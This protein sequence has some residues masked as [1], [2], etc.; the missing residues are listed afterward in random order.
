M[1]ALTALAAW[2]VGKV[3]PDR[4]NDLRQTIALTILV[5]LLVGSPALNA[6]RRRRAAR[7][8]ERPGEA[9]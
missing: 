8:S 2:Q 4:Y 1:Y 9:P 6:Y 5:A 3:I 7:S